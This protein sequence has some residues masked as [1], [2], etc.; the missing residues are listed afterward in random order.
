MPA[1]AVAF[2]SRLPALDTPSFSSAISLKNFDKVSQMP[3]GRVW[4][5]CRDP[6]A[7]NVE[8]RVVLH[9]FRGQEGGKGYLLAL[10]VTVLPHEGP[11]VK[12]NQL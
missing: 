12:K 6:L 11:S 8:E 10:L 3:V 4:V 9:F 7:N 2:A 1:C 5:V